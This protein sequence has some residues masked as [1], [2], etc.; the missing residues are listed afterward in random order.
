M[1]RELFGTDGIRGEANSHP[2]TAEIALT[3]GRATGRLFRRGDYRHRVLIGKDTRLSGYMIEPALVAG[4]VSAGMDVTLVGPMPTPAVAFLTRSMRAD[5]GVMISASHN[6]FKDN[7]I[8]LFGPDGYKLS[9][10]I[11]AEIEAEMSNMDANGHAAP[12]DLG[13]ARRIE[14]ARGRY[15]ENLKSSFPKGLNLN[16]LKIV[17]DCAHGAAYNIGRD[18]LF[19]LG[20]D[21]IALGVAPNGLNIN[22]G[23][24]SMHPEF[25]GQAVREQGADLGISLDGDADRLILVD[26]TGSTIDGDQVLA[27]IA[28]D[29]SNHDRL[30]GGRIAATLMSN[31]GL[32]TFLADRGIELVRTKV[33]DR[34]VVA[35]MR[36]Q[37]LNVGGEQ[38]GHIILNDFATT[39]DGLLAALQVLAVLRRS[40]RPLSEVGRCFE[41]MPQKLKNVRI[42]R[43][44]DLAQP[45]VKALID[46][47]DRR[48]DGHGRLVVRPSGTEPLIRVMVEAD[49]DNLLNEVLNHVAS[50][51]DSHSRAAQV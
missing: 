40:D 13:R 1:T 43:P 32:Q 16:G 2:M 7:G 27:L 12:E 22:D 18:L 42:D 37:G 41:P 36:E 6:P 30:R 25:V 51:I 45:V 4:F 35:A 11:E 8:K 29:W 9:D 20:A 26:E 15:I 50:G 3:L 28:V 19:E 38:S 49:C 5:I 34:Y 31:F 47:A 21:V 10:A 39:G 17:I 46:D 14:D 33:G 23:C 44:V 24:G 48:L